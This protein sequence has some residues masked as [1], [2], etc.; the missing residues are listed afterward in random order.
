MLVHGETIRLTPKERKVL[1]RLTGIDPH[2]IRDRAG[3]IRYADQFLKNRPTDHPEI[4]LVK[5]LL[6][7]YLVY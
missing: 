1:R 6:R 2:F 7:K 5:L 4:R 3:L